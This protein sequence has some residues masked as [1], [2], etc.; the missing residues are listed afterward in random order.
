MW[1]RYRGRV[2]LAMSAQAFA[3]LVRLF[4]LWYAKPF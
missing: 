3:Q 1:T 2:L 4:I